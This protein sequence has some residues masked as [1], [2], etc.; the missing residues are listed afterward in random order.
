MAGAGGRAGEMAK[1][2]HEL[3]T[4]GSSTSVGSTAH[5]SWSNHFASGVGM[6]GMEADH[7]ALRAADAQLE[8]IQ[9]QLVGQLRDANELTERLDDGSSPVADHMRNRFHA[10][11]NAEEGVVAAL[12][13]YL[14]E[15]IAVRIAIAHSLAGYLATDEGSALS[16]R[17]QGEVR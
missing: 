17:Q 14:D 13:D 12:A 3:E 16:L 2:G 1:G 10:R 9:H 5:I 15:V 6:H 7:E 11:A 8:E 4:I